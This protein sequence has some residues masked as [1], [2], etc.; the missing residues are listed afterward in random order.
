[1]EWSRFPVKAMPKLGWIPGGPD[2]VGRAEEIIRDLI[3]RAGGPDIAGTALYRKNNHMR[4]NATM[5]PYALKAWCWQVL[6]T[7]NE[8]RPQPN[9]KRGAITLDFLKKV[10]RLSWSEDG[11][12]L[13]KNFLAKHGIPL[14]V[15]QHL[16]KTYLDGAA[17]PWSSHV[18][19]IPG[20]RASTEFSP[21]MIRPTH[22]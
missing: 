6:A 14:V 11:P 21:D 8:D 9:Y 3:D 10:A 15:V 20:G 17:F 19:P 16:P 5:D 18:S 22:S 1:M 7:A 12:R 4:S 2:L 13:A